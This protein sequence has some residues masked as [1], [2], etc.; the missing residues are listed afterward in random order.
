MDGGRLRLPARMEDQ[1]WYQAIIFRILVKHEGGIVVGT[2][3]VFVCICILCRIFYVQF[4]SFEEARSMST[5]LSFT[6]NDNPRKSQFS[7]LKLIQFKV[8]VELKRHLFPF[9]G[10]TNNYLPS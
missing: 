4:L 5:I 2:D 6:K 9:Y 7:E 1:V 3:L 10:R 8:R